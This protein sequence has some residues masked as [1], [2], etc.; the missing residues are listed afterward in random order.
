MA[1]NNYNPAQAGMGIGQTGL[2]DPN[3]VIKRKNR[4]TF[5]VAS[6]KGSDCEFS[7]PA[8]FC[9][10]AARPN[11][12]IEDTQLDFLNDRTWIPGKATWE[13]IQVTY[14][15]VGGNLG[16]PS[17]DAVRGV[18]KWLGSVYDFTGKNGRR[19]SSKRA[20]YSGRAT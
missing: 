2:G 7:I 1:A 10:I 20:G 3:V 8:H 16:S 6:L 18:Y 13:T 9:K 17:I 12:T 15:D 14:I 5:E 11:I 4:W 19:Q